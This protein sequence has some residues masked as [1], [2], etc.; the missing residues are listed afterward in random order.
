MKI[1]REIGDLIVDN[2]PSFIQPVKDLVEHATNLLNKIK[3]DFMDFYN[4]STIQRN[5]ETAIRFF[6]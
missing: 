4:V 3:S 5:L 1:A 6:N 2:L